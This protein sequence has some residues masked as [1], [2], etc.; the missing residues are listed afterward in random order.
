MK[1]CLHDPET[2]VSLHDA[3]QVGRFR[4]E[5]GLVSD[6]MKEGHTKNCAQFQVFQDNECT[7]THGK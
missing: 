1:G 2:K 6:L 4:I 3:Q 7:C 5:L